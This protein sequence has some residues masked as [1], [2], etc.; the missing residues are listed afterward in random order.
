[1][2]ELPRCVRGDMRAMIQRELESA[3]SW[4]AAGSGSHVRVRLTTRSGRQVQLTLPG[5]D[6]GGRCLL[7]NQAMLRREIST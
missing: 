6:G 1:M 7:N 2:P 4:S 3:V 5:R